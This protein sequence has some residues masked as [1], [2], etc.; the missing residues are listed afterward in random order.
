MRHAVPPPLGFGFG[1]GLWPGLALPAAAGCC[2][3]AA[4]TDA[5]ADACADGTADGGT[6]DDRTAGW[7]PDAIGAAATRKNADG[8]AG[9]RAAHPARIACRELARAAEA[10]RYGGGAAMIAAR[11]DGRP[12]RA[13]TAPATL[14]PQ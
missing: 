7:A 8:P 1:F 3:A 11:C 13:R 9:P 2:A 10:A 5:N 14:L 4:R 6:A 12:I